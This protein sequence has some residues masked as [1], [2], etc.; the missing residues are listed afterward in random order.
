MY[1][2]I[3]VFCFSKNLIQSTQKN[4]YLYR[5]I[6]V[7]SEFPSIMCIDALHLCT[8]KKANIDVPMFY[9]SLSYLFLLL[10]YLF[11]RGASLFPC[12]IPH[13]ADLPIIIVCTQGDN[14]LRKS[15]TSPP[16]GGG[17]QSINQLYTFQVM[18]RK[19]LALSKKSMILLAL[20]TTTAVMMMRWIIN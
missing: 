18:H 8:E 10:F 9:L 19:N 13:F 17:V 15:N 3:Y 12:C 5:Y 1:R 7:F 11:F 2:Y 14:A 20:T 4:A 6:Y 16:T